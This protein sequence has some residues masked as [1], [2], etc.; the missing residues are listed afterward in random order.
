[1]KHLMILAVFL[2]TVFIAAPVSKADTLVFLANL[3]DFE[4]PPTGSPGT[5]FARVT[6]DTVANTMRVEVTFSGLTSNNTAA[7]I[8]ASTPAPFTGNA[9]VATTT[10]TFTGFPGGVTAGTYDHTFDMTLATSYNPA[11]VTAN[12][13]TAA[14]AE[15][16]LFAGIIAGRSYLNIHTSNFG[17]GE[18]R[19]FLVAQTPEPATMLL[20]GSG[21]AGLALKLRRRRKAQQ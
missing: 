6:L 16:A 7:H 14:S 11:F 21:V 12:G 8:H 4:S 3:G 18:I 20:F 1:M 17:G 10:P 5:G 2:A 15:A 13:G 19:G 9:G